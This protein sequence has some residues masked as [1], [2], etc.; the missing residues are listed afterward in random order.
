M[1]PADDLEKAVR[2]LLAQGKLT[3]LI[4][5]QD[6]GC[7]IVLELLQQRVI[8]LGR[9]ERIAPGHGRGQE[10][11]DIG[12]TCGLSQACGQEG[13]ARPRVAHENAI[14]LGWSKSN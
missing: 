14:T 5:D 9:N 2:T 3:Q 10:H 1:P 12:V 7:V 13:L 11:L 6:V 8:R 4:P